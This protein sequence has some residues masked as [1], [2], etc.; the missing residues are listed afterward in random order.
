MQ[1]ADGKIYKND[2]SDYEKESASA[3]V[4][5]AAALFLVVLMQ[6]LRID[7]KGKQGISTHAPIQLVCPVVTCSIDD[8]DS[9]TDCDPVTYASGPT[10][11][12]RCISNDLYLWIVF[13]IVNQFYGVTFPHYCGAILF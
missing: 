11:Q 3:A 13:D 1:T 7:E 8:V 10:G 4:E 2:E 5:L 9:I 12:T 6:S